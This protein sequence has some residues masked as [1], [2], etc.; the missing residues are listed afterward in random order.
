M[1]SSLR[2]LTA[3][4][5]AFTLL[6]PVSQDAASGVNKGPHVSAAKALKLLR[7]GNNRFVSGR[8]IHA[9]T[10]QSRRDEVVKGQEPFVTVLACADSRVPVE[11]IFD[12][13]FGDLFVIRSA[14]NFFEGDSLIG[15]AEY[16]VLHTHTKLVLVLGHQHCGAVG[17]GLN[18]TGRLDENTSIPG[19]IKQLKPGIDKARQTT[20]RGGMLYNEAIEQNVLASVA[21]FLNKS[22]KVGRM[23]AGY[24]PDGKTR[25]G[26]SHKV[27]VVGAVYNLET[28]RVEFLGEHP[29]QADMLLQHIKP[30]EK[31]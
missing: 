20:L 6:L 10:S 12:H 13:G 25:L 18:G 26:D 21:N 2:L 22:T 7:E 4:L 31:K 11:R 29:N 9:H 19:L 16:G 5:A 30:H 14:G 8:I 3:F 23:V 17:A 28:G 27:M 15:T 24:S 1:R